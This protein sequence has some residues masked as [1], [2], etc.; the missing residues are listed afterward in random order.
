ML[1]TPPPVP[2]EE[3]PPLQ[4]PAVKPEVFKYAKQ[5]EKSRETTDCSVHLIE[6]YILETERGQGRIYRIKLTILQRLSN[7]EYLG[8]LYV[9]RDYKEGEKSGASCR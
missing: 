8:E 6:E 3:M 2:S 4:P 1:P 9:D 5:Y 7:L